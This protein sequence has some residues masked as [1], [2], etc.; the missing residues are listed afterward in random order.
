MYNGTFKFI[1]LGIYFFCNVRRVRVRKENK[2]KCVSS[3]VKLVLVFRWKYIKFNKIK[4]VVLTVF[5][6]RW[7]LVYNNN[8]N[9]TVNTTWEYYY[10]ENFLLF[11]PRLGSFSF[12]LIFHMVCH[13]LALA[14]RSNLISTDKKVS[15]V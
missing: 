9:K 2:W 14:P 7:S 11:S 8:I 5:F 1:R 3:F 12:I 15:S 10:Y 13:V 4:V 6:Y